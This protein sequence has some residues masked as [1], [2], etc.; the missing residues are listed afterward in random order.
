MYRH[1]GFDFELFLVKLAGWFLFKNP[2]GVSYIL[3]EICIIYLDGILFKV[4]FG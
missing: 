3:Y 4:A 2:V 1:E